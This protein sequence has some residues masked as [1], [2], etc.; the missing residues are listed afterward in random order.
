M[1]IELPEAHILA[2]QMNKELRGKHVKSYH[3]QDYE[4]LQKIGFMNKDIK[5]F[6]QLVNGNIE[7]VESR[8]SVMRVKLDNGM[9]LLLAPE[10]GGRVTYHKSKDTVPS[11]FHLRVDFTD[12]T[13]LAV[14]LTGMGLIYALKDGELERSYLYKRDFTSEVPSPIND[15]EFTFE[16]FSKLLA[17]RKEIIKSLLVGK[18]AIVVGLG[19]SAYQDIIYRARIHPKKKAPELSEDQK[20]AL[21]D[22]IKL[23]LQER[24]RLGGKDQFF[25]LYGKQGGYKPA[26]GSHVKTCPVCGTSIEKLSIG[27]GH[28]YFC[29]KCQK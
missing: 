16:R 28:T 2:Q 22:A 18:D 10:Y 29:P 21:Y 23:M 13:I 26:M 11:K 17:G 9:N 12:S 6:D 14:R 15:K 24:I 19:N 1:S 25:D 4:R 3:L 8:G 7:S 5:S 20:R 27:G